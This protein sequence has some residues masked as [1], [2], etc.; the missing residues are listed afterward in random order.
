MVTQNLISSST[1]VLFPLKASAVPRVSTVLRFASLLFFQTPY[2]SPHC[3][4]LQYHHQPLVSREAATAVS[5]LRLL[6]DSIALSL[7]SVDLSGLVLN[8]PPSV[9]VY[10]ISF[11]SNLSMFFADFCYLN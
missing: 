11:S 6:K 10:N 9:V 5:G 3:E 8:H 2:S 4:A 7:P 1:T